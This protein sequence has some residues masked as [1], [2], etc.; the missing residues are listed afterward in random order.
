MPDEREIPWVKIITGVGGAI[1]LAAAG[2]G[3]YNAN[4]E[5][6]NA[7]ASAPALQPAV[8][9]ARVLVNA[10]DIAALKNAALAM[11]VRIQGNGE[12][13]ATLKAEM[14]ALHELAG[15]RERRFLHVEAD[16]KDAQT[17]QD[18]ILDRLRMLERNAR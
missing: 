2:F 6:D 16:Q 8:L 11:S 10:T 18:Q 9:D 4:R 1:G 7:Q 17:R 15:E 13:I 14:K 12:E 5:R 3:T